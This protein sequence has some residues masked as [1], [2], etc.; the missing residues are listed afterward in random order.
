[1]DYRYLKKEIETEKNLNEKRFFEAYEQQ[2][3]DLVATLSN[4]IILQVKD[5]VRNYYK[6]P[7]LKENYIRK[8]I[9][10]RPSL[11]RRDYLFESDSK[12]VICKQ[13]DD[14]GG[15]YDNLYS[16]INYW[17]VDMPC[18]NV[19]V[20]KIDIFWNLLNQE[21]FDNSIRVVFIPDEHG[22]WYNIHI[23]AN[24]GKL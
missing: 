17:D 19:P 7:I 22:S 13:P 2:E 1:M 20:S 5:T 18:V 21:L 4:H 3:K 24:L 11:F 23:N 12:D 6:N 16:T 15:P 10:M 8:R 9:I 14:W